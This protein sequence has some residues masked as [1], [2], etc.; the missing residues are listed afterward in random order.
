M[1]EVAVRATSAIG[2][3]PTK[4]LAGSGEDLVDAMGVL[5]VDL[6]GVAMVTEAAG[7][8]DGENCQP[9][10]DFSCWVNLT[11]MTREGKVLVEHAPEA[12]ADAGGVDDDVLRTPGVGEAFELAKDGE[13]ALADPTVAGDDW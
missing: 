7:L 11:G 5:E 2:D 13:V 6:I 8:D 12:F 1:E 9:I 3:A 4:G 10:S